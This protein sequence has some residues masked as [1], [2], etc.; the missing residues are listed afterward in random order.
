M[1]EIK[2]KPFFLEIVADA[3]AQAEVNLTDKKER[4][5]WVNAIAKGVQLLDQRSEFITFMPGDK[6]LV[7]WSDSNEVYAANGVCQCRAYKNGL[8]IRNKPFP[9]K[10]RALARIVRLYFELQEKPNRQSSKSS[11]AV[12]QA[13]V[14]SDIAP[15][16]P[17][18]TDYTQIPYLKPSSNK[19][20]ERVGNVRI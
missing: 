5:R 1:L 15:K 12:S 2:D 11:A 4:T 9:C 7:I 17:V 14:L 8:N 3:I 13:P 18:K 10:H 19:K 20:P 16:A 6:S